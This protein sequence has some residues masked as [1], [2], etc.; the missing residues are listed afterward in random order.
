MNTL[1]TVTTLLSERARK[2]GLPEVE[3]TENDGLRVLSNHLV[4]V[5]EGT[6]VDNTNAGV[7]NALIEFAS[8]V[9]DED[10]KDIFDKFKQVADAFSLRFM[11]SYEELKNIKETVSQLVASSEEMAKSIIS[12][13]PVLASL[14]SDQSTTTK[15]KPIQWGY[16]DNVSELE[17]EQRLLN[18]IGVDHIAEGNERY[19]HGLMIAHLPGGPANRN[20]DFAPLTLTK[21]KMLSM[22]D[23]LSSRISNYSKEEVQSIFAH[24]LHLDKIDCNKNINAINNMVTGTSASK[25]NYILRMTNAYNAVMRQISEESL[26]LSRSTMEG[27]TQ[28]VNAMHDFIDLTT[29]L[30]MY[31]RNTI[32]R[33]AIVVPGMLVNTDNWAEFCQADKQIIKSNPTLAILQYKN[34]V[35]EDRDIPVYGINGQTII[36]RCDNIAKEAY[37]TASANTLRCNQKK[38]EIYR[39]SFIAIAGRWLRQQ[40]NFSL[41]Y[42]NDNPEHFAA[43]IYDSNRDDA[44]ENMYYSVIMNS[45]YVNTLTSMIHKRLRDEYKKAMSTANTLTERDIINLDTKVLADLMTEYLVDHLLK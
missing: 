16:L 36:D 42:H 26:D 4:T 31:Y 8:I 30:C 20:V 25:I 38:K 43:S 23:T 3:F 39:D 29:Y 45:C 13:N 24:I 1:N 28:R 21:G 34:K 44:V 19:I 6:E 2:N 5:S 37:E 7:R 27:V 9:R 32:W 17:L 15:L 22:I 11:N 10:Y 18:K 41:E 35:Y 12:E 40:K 33:D 14:E